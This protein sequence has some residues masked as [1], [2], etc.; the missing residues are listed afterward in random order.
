MLPQIHL[1][2]TGIP[3]AAAEIDRDIEKL[4]AE[5]ANE[6]VLAY[7]R[8]IDQPKSGRLYRKGSIRGRGIRG[9]RRAAGTSTRRVV[10][11]RIHRASAPGEAIASDSGSSRKDITVRRLKAGHFRVRVG[12]WAGFW[13]FVAKDRTSR[14]YTI[15]PAIEQ[16]VDKVFNQ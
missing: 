12:G 11:T 13:E 14:R 15:I 7:Q 16:A 1:T 6:I 9:L 3:Q 2:I 8:L 5:L 4:E 10:G